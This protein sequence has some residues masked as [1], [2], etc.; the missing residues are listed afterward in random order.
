MRQRDARQDSVGSPVRL[1]QASRL[2]KLEKA[3]PAALY[4]SVAG[5]WE[6]PM[7]G[8]IGVRFFGGKEIRTRDTDRNFPSPS[9]LALIALEAP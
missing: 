6:Q 8:R 1:G 7:T 4:M 5:T 2:A 9:T 3:L